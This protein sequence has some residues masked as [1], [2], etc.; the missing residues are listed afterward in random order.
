MLNYSHASVWQDSYG[1]SS[2]TG[3]QIFSTSNYHFKPC[4]TNTTH[5]TVLVKHFAHLDRA[6]FSNG[7]QVALLKIDDIGHIQDCTTV[8]EKFFLDIQSRANS[9]SCTRA[10]LPWQLHA[11]VDLLKLH[12]LYVCTY[13]TVLGQ[14]WLSISHAEMI[15]RNGC[16]NAL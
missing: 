2:V 14:T 5:E 13:S 11:R 6:I 4:S 16:R 10:I 9:T 15:T 3:C 12:V 7:C 1:V 8:S